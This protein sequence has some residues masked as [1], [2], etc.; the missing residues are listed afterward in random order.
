MGKTNSGWFKNISTA[1][2]VLAVL[3]MASGCKVANRRPL[4]VAPFNPGLSPS[5]E[6]I[7]VQFEDTL[8][9]TNLNVTVWD[10]ANGA[11]AD[12]REAKQIGYTQNYNRVVLAEAIAPGAG[13]AAGPWLVQT[14]IVIPFGPIF[15]GTFQSGLKEAFPNAVILTNATAVV[16]TT[17]A[18]AN[19]RL[20]VR[21]SDFR[22]WEQPLNHIN[23]T[24]TVTCRVQPL[25]RPAAAASSFEVCRTATQ[26]QVGTMLSTSGG[27]IRKM[28]EIANTFAGQVTQE[29]LE[30]LQK[31]VTAPGPMPQP[32]RTSL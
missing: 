32:A 21:V 22:V 17:A 11:F 25:G 19:Y 8:P 13:V 1:F 31:E 16:A 24:T 4:R 3:V 26:Q 14:R 9:G 27:F 7:F 18:D 29:I 2:L 23:L 28:N 15:M 30:K 6:K 20:Q 10:N 12:A 5:A